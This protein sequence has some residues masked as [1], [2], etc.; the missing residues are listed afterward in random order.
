MEENVLRLLAP[1]CLVEGCYG[2][3]QVLVYDIIFD[4][5]TTQVPPVRKRLCK[6]EYLEKGLSLATKLSRYVEA[7]LSHVIN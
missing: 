3:K 5:P 1:H 4:V 7:K 2:W 6:G